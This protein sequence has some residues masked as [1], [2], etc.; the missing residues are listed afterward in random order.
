MAMARWASNVV[1]R[2]IGEAH[3]RSISDDLRR[4][5]TQREAEH[6]LVQMARSQKKLK[7]DGVLQKAVWEIEDR[8]KLLESSENF[9]VVRNLRTGALH[10]TCMSVCAPSET[11][12]TICGWKFA[13]QG[14]R[15]QLIRGSDN[16]A[17]S[18]CDKCFG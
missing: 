10:R 16:D 5:H 6:M 11:W 2:Y 13:S 9:D 3:L 17:F 14:A 18:R 15:Y 4:I 8:L 12:V 7:D 1:L